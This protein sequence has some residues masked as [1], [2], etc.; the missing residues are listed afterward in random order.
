MAGAQLE[1]AEK[2][3]DRR[4]SV[5]PPF[6]KNQEEKMYSDIKKLWRR[7]GGLKVSRDRVYMA[8]IGKK[9]GLSVSKDKEHMSKIGK[10]S[11]ALRTAARL[12]REVHEGV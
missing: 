5:G 4:Y 10:I 11:G 7:K 9:G 6:Y 8:I 1:W 12:K 3:K 2:R